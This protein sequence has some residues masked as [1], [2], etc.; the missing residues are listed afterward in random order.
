M[1]STRKIMHTA[2]YMFPG[3]IKLKAIVTYGGDTNGIT[4]HTAAIA[5]LKV[6]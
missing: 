3:M 5:A 4:A 1:M 6:A 2:L